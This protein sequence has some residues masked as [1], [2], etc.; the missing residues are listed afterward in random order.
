ME[1]GA[2]SVPWNGAVT[3][4]VACEML[5]VV[6]LG[7]TA[8]KIADPRNPDGHAAEVD[9]VGVPLVEPL[10]GF[11]VTA[12]GLVTE[13]AWAAHAPISAA[14]TAMP[15]DHPDNRPNRALNTDFPLRT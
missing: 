14:P 4:F 7:R 10:A 12:A 1:T 9:H 2:C 3:P 6:P 8:R 11:S 13:E 5:N 15:A